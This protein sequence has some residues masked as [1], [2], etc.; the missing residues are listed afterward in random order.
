MLRTAAIFA[1]VALVGFAC[2]ILFI[3]KGTRFRHHKTISQVLLALYVLRPPFWFFYEHFC[4]FPTY[5]N[6]EGGAN[7]A[8]LKSA[9]DVT[10][11]LWAAFAVVLCC[12]TRNSRARWR[13]LLSPD[14]ADAVPPVRHRRWPTAVGT[15]EHPPRRGP[16]IANES[17][18]GCSRLVNLRCSES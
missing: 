11:K 9:Q 2:T 6:F 13:Q 3:L 16:W 17:V 7:T 14:T 15:A 4:Y 18:A 1:V 12:I 8:A 10:S 5:G